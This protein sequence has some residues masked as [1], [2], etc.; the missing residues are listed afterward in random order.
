VA[1]EATVTALVQRF[2]RSPGSGAHYGWVHHLLCYISR[3]SLLR[4]A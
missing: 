2:M 4:R 1:I 3:P